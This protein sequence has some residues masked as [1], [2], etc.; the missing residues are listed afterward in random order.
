[1]M[2]VAGTASPAMGQSA[3]G[4]V[5]IGE[6]LVR[7]Q[8]AHLRR[9]AVWG[10]A[11]LLAGLGL[12][13][14]SRDGSPGRRGFGIQSAA[15][16]AINLGIVAWATAAGSEPPGPGLAGVLEAENAWGDILLLN[17]GLN[18]GYVAVGTTLAV[19]A[20]RGLRSGDAVRGHGLGIIVQGLGLLALDGVAYAASRGRMAALQRL[21]EQVDVGAVDD[22][23]R[24]GI[25]VPF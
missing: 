16:G 8:D 21:L 25:S 23:V 15:W 14:A 13:A 20:G 11:S 10:G 6:A 17:L 1:M 12:I 24:I 9:V 19:A 18:V 5:E 3:P 4:A 22:A 7:S 2:A